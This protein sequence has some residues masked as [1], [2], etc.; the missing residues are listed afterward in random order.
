MSESYWRWK[1]YDFD[2]NLF[3]TIYATSRQSLNKRV[4]DFLN[5]QQ[6]PFPYVN[7]AT[8]EEKCYECGTWKGT[9]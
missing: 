4:L 6:V 2:G 5:E 9:V 7:R 1:A 8:I 3:T